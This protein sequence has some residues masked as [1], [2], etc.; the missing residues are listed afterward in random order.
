MR[1]HFHKSPKAEGKLWP[2]STEGRLGW[3]SGHA[4]Q[5]G[6]SCT[7]RGFTQIKD[8]KLEKHFRKS[9]DSVLYQ[10]LRDTRALGH[11]RPVT[12]CF[13]HKTN[14]KRCSWKIVNFVSASLFSFQRLKTQRS[15]KMAFSVF[16]WQQDIS[17]KYLYGPQCRREC[18]FYML[19]FYFG[20]CLQ[21]QNCASASA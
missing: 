8:L 16:C 20:F 14:W 5:Q 18:I 21:L 7:A 17:V 6:D 11:P 10:Q 3:Y 2:H 1:V 12:P 13:R 15:L 4:A 19:H 9:Y